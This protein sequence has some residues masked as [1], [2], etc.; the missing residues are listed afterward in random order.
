MHYSMQVEPHC[1][2]FSKVTEIF[3]VSE[4]LGILQYT[5]WTGFNFSYF[6]C[7]QSIMTANKFQWQCS[8]NSKNEPPHDKTNKMTLSPVKTQISLGI[9]PVWSESSLCAQ[10]VA[11][12]QAFFSGQLRLWSDW[13][14]AQA[15]LSLHWAHSHFGGFVM[16]RL[17]LWQPKK[18][19]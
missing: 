12:D 14:D 9:C 5:A 16:R 7:Q 8:K 10:W 3:W 19:L 6:R 1:L 4:Y 11:K 15:D 18:L 17:K 13:A 2:N